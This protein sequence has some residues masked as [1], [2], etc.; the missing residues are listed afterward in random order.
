[1]ASA[2]ERGIRAVPSPPAAPRLADDV[3]A[4]VAAL[5]SKL[6]PEDAALAALALRY[7]QTID[8]AAE[9]AEL[10][11]AVPYDPDTAQTV[12]RLRQRVDAHAVMAEVG[13]KLQA[14]LT[15]LGA[16]PRARAAA[17]KP[18]PAGRGG[19]LAALRGGGA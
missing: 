8:T 17:A 16:T 3:A 7:A 6:Q 4:T 15:E 12:A 9:L 2:R 13:P 10:A 14:A 5:E 18:A 19:K 11:A 1:M